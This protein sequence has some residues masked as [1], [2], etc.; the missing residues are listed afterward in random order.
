MSYRTRKFWKAFRP[1]CVVTL[2]AGITATL[3]LAWMFHI[4]Q[5]E[6]P[7]QRLGLTSLGLVLLLLGCIALA[8]YLDMQE[9]IRTMLWRIEYG[10]TRVTMGC[11]MEQFARYVATSYSAFLI[12][13]PDDTVLTIGGDWTVVLPVLE[14][15]TEFTLLN[16]V[17][18]KHYATVTNLKPL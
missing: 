11:P 18:Y 1:F 5:H 3:A 6:I 14:T 8:Q 2:L 4:D 7:W 13:S 17:D 12:R 15:H 10:H 9:K 16:P